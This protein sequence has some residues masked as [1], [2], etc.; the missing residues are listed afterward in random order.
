[1]VGP[2]K[3]GVVITPCGRANDLWNGVHVDAQIDGQI[4]VSPAADRLR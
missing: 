1:M 3:P 4:F 2:L